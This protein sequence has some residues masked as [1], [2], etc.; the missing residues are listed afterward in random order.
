MIGKIIIPQDRKSVNLQIRAMDR[1]QM[2]DML[3][4]M[5]RF[6]LD[7]MAKHRIA[8]EHKRYCWERWDAWNRTEDA[9]HSKWLRLHNEEVIEKG[10]PEFVMEVPENV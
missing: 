4:T 1:R 10:H 7:M 2:M 8:E 3:M 6:A 9:L 5:R